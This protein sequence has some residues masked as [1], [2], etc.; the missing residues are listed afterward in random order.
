MG[1]VF[2]LHFSVFS[3]SRL[4]GPRPGMAF[5]VFRGCP[6]RKESLR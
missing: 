4:L 6:F 1:Q 3:G 5:R 2:S